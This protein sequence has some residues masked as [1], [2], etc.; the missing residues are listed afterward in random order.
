M[1]SGGRIANAGAFQDTRTGHGTCC[2][3]DLAPGVERARA[4]RPGDRDTGGTFAIEQDT[5]H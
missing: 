2:K 3:H 4:A 5:V 1:K